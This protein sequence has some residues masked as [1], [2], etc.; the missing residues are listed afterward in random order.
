MIP[1]VK[2]TL[3]HNSGAVSLFKPAQ[4]QEHAAAGGVRE[5]IITCSAGE[6]GDLFKRVELLR[7]DM[8]GADW[9]ALVDAKGY[10]ELELRLKRAANDL[11]QGF[12]PHVVVTLGD[13]R[14][15]RSARL[16]TNPG[17]MALMLDNSRNRSLQ[18]PRILPYQLGGNAEGAVAV[19][20]V[21]ED[22]D[23]VKKGIKLH[24]MHPNEQEARVSEENLK[25]KGAGSTALLKVETAVTALVREVLEGKFKPEVAAAVAEIDARTVST[26]G[27]VPRPTIRPVPTPFEA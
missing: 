27:S 4:P 12:E 3:S 24:S 18:V 20:Y 14:A 17:D 25:A 7:S 10:S 8:A 1:T 2:V 11:M 23:G 6:P 13:D 16:V 26:H 9:K 5:A 15:I 19:I 22:A 21:P